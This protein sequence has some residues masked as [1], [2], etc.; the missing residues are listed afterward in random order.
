MNRYIVIMIIGICFIIL[1]ILLMNSSTI[2]LYKLFPKLYKI[3]T[4][5]LSKPKFR[6]F[7]YFVLGEKNYRK[8]LNAFY[9]HRRKKDNNE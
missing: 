6:N 4:K 3:D 8:E 9:L 5:L 7:L 1:S 2:L